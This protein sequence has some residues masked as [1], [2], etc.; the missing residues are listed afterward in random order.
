MPKRFDGLYL[1][2]AVVILATV[3]LQVANTY[4]GGCLSYH[5][6]DFLENI[7]YVWLT[8]SLVHFNWM[9]WFLNIINLVAIVVL[10]RR[11]WNTKRLLIVFAISSALIVINLYNFNPDVSSYVGM[12]GVLYALVVYGGLQNLRY[13]KIISTVVLVY[14]ALKLFFG[15][16][17]NHVM[18]VDVALSGL[19]VIRE[20]HWY[21]AGIGILIYILFNLKKE[22]LNPIA[23]S[24]SH[25]CK[26]AGSS[27]GV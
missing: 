9:H 21:G 17:V 3:L 22:R 1:T 10:F 6:V 18:G 4:F 25:S 8:P 13:D 20:V 2:L 19:K 23:A 11:V 15:E 7:Y 5:R 12:S 16:T 24:S 14:A 26:R 27:D